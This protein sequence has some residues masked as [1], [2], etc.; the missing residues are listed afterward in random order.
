MTRDVFGPV[1]GFDLARLALVRPALQAFV[2]RGELAGVVTLT[3]QGGQVVQSEAVGW[4]DLETRT[5]MRSDTLFRIASMTKPITSAAALMLVEE[6]RIALDDP[7]ARWIPELADPLVLRD[8][9]G[10]LRD[11]TPAR[12]PITVEDLLSFRAGLGFDL[13]VGFPTIPLFAA[14]AELGLAIG[15]P[16]PP[17][18][19]TGELNAPAGFGCSCSRPLTCRCT[20][21]TRTAWLAGVV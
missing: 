8:A 1:R 2:D 13:D 3:S 7:I 15:P 11:V 5:P 12:R 21:T 19:C 20:V 6:G 14:A 9:A 17:S 10:P 18:H 16:V 4:S